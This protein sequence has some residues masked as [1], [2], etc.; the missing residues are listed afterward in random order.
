MKR[1]SFVI[2]LFCFFTG[3]A[4]SDD[5]LTAC[6]DMDYP[7]FTY[8]AEL[9]AHKDRVGLKIG[10]TIK[11]VCPEIL[12]LVF[13]ELGIKVDSR[14]AGNWKR[15]QK[16]VEEGKVDIIMGAYKTEEREDIYAYPGTPVSTDPVTIFVWKSREFK[17]DQ[18]DDLKGKRVGIAR[19]TSAGQSFDNWLK[20]NA[21]VDV[22]PRRVNN[23]KKMEIGRIDCC[24]GG[25]YAELIEINSYGFKGK[26]VPLK[27]SVKAENIY[28]A[29]S[30]KSEF[31]K[32][33]PHL[34]D[35]LKKL[36]ADGTVDRLI[37]KHLEQYGVM[38]H[39]KMQ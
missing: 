20:K 18:W 11:G 25:K 29:I 32:Y 7:P 34:E 39:N 6:G 14:Y 9:S 33:L 19:G 24:V 1:L 26:V 5:I 37:S 23:Y 10:D 31:V 8:S 3:S 30:K 13:G 27:N 15:C 12:E 35:G 2:A 21:S 38:R 17:F 4:R 16:T 28:V 36:H 22:A